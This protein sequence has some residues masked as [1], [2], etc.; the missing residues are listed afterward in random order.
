MLIVARHL[1]TRFAPHLAASVLSTDFTSGKVSTG[2]VLPAPSEES[3][4]EWLIPSLQCEFCKYFALL[5]FCPASLPPLDTAT[6]CSAGPEAG[7]E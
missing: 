5:T 6:A 4:A 1:W 3:L 2:L 7:P